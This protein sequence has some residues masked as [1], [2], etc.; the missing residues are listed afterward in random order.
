MLR[1]TAASGFMDFQDF[2]YGKVQNTDAC[3]MN[4]KMQLA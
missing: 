2:Q 3:G 1:Q 4:K